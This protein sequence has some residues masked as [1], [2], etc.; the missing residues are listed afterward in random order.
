MPYRERKISK[1]GDVVCDCCGAYLGNIYT[2]DYFA[3]LRQKYC[4]KCGEYMLRQMWRTASQK[5]RK[6]IKEERKLLKEQNELIKEE[7]EL[8]RKRIIELRREK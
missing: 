7:N 4:E 1:D 2:G 3:L 8:L 6:R 5:R